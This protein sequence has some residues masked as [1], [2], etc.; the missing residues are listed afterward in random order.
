MKF[1][2][3]LKIMQ[4]KGLGEGMTNRAMLLDTSFSAK[5][6]YDYLVHTGVEVYIVGGNPSDGLAKSVNNYINLDYSRIDEL[7]T[8]LKKTEN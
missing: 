3:Q 6:I 5:P 8:L 1:L 2:K 4:I 7:K